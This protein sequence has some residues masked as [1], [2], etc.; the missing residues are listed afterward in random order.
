MRVDSIEF[1]IPDDYYIKSFPDNDTLISEFGKFFTQYS[2]EANSLLY[3]RKQVIKEG[4]YD[5]KKYTEFRNYLK[6]I[7]RADKSKVLLMP[8]E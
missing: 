4:R 6:S 7:S 3:V 5:S 8:K 1:I 2:L